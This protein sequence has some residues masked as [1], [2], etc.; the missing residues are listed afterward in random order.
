MEADASLTGF[1]PEVASLNASYT[2]PRA[3]RVDSY[4]KQI[5]KLL[6]HNFIGVGTRT[7]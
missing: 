2:R 7:R 4:D 3:L 1:S 6:V 5:I